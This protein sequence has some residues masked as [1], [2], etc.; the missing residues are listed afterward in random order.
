[1][2]NHDTLEQILTSL[3]DII[4][5]NNEDSEIDVNELNESTQ[6]I[7]KN[8]ILDS[9]TL[10]SLIV[11]VEQKVNDQYNL[12]ITVADERAMS[13]EKSPFRTIRTLADYVNM[14][15]KEQL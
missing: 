8:A 6:L 1:M 4:E 7:G 11:D 13:Q 3:R 12:T 2:E 10:V 15:V 14:L 5:E 9:L